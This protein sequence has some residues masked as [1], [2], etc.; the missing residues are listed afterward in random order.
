MAFHELFQQLF[1]HLKFSVCQKIESEMN[2]HLS[3]LFPNL[4]DQIQ[5]AFQSEKSSIIHSNCKNP[6]FQKL[7]M[8]L[9]TEKT[10]LQGRM[11]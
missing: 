7:N 9:E 11:T 8:C 4:L 2:F 6:Y 10:F 5:R 1:L 3:A